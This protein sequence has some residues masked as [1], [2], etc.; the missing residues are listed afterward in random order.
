MLAAGGVFLLLL[1]FISIRKQISSPIKNQPRNIRG[2]ISYKRSFN[3][4]NPVQLASARRHGIKPVKN[5]ESLEEITDRLHKIEDCEHYIVDRLTH[6]VP[7]LVPR[8]E[9]LLKDIGQSFADSLKSKGLNPN[10]LIVTSLLR[11]VEDQRKLSRGNTNAAR[12]SCHSY[13]TTF[14]ITY[15]RFHKKKFKRWHPY[16]NVSAE[17]LKK[18]LSEV[19]R[20]K[21]K[22]KRCHV[23]YELRQGCFHITTR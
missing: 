20:D 3:D 18:V 22:E 10:R 14:D 11:T 21:K 17:T 12:K 2:V 9:L 5:R 7:Y 19:L 8:A 1:A 13:A 15:K 6:S 16:E 4:L 23:K